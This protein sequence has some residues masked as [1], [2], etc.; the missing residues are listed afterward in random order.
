MGLELKGL[1]KMCEDLGSLSSG[2]QG[3]GKGLGFMGLGFR[4]RVD[5]LRVHL[6]FTLV[7]WRGWLA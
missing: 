6:S 2:V 5:C 7:N 4:L 3:L 1:E